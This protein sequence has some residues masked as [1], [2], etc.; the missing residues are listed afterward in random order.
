MPVAAA[1]YYPLF[2]PQVL[3]DPRFYE[4]LGLLSLL[5]DSGRDFY[6]RPEVLK[7][8]GI[9]LTTAEAFIEA[10]RAYG[11][12]GP[13]EDGERRL[14]EPAPRLAQLAAAGELLRGPEGGSWDHYSTPQAL[15][16]LGADWFS[17]LRAQHAA[18]PRAGI[19][20]EGQGYGYRRAELDRLIDG[21]VE[22]LHRRRAAYPAAVVAAA[23]A[24]G[25]SRVADG[26]PEAAVLRSLAAQGNGHRR[27]NGAPAGPLWR[28][29]LGLFG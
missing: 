21:A 11:F 8:C 18:D 22:P 29:A 2:D 28:R 25:G 6:V 26:D 1:P 3:E 7:S 23:G 16:L 20:P 13:E 17:A 24:A 10:M 14:I 27:V 12:L 19:A 5:A 15:Q 9:D 4:A